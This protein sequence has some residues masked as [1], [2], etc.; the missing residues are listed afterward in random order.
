M[1]LSMCTMEFLPYFMG[2]QSGDGRE[3]DGIADGVGEEDVQVV[4]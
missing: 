4:V 2:C 1:G 3:E